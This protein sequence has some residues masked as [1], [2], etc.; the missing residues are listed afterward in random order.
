MRGCGLSIPLPC[1]MA[2]TTGRRKL[3]RPSAE[4]QPPPAAA[5]VSAPQDSGPVEVP[6]KS[7]NTP[8][9]PPRPNRKVCGSGVKMGVSA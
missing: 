7:I 4:A 9:P 2:E 6:S 1:Q 3:R 5:S 8:V